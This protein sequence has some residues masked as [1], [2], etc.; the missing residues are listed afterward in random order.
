MIEGGV[1]DILGDQTL[2]VDIILRLGSLFNAFGPNGPMN[3]FLYD[4][5]CVAVC[6]WVLFRVGSVFTPA[7]HYDLVSDWPAEKLQETPRIKAVYGSQ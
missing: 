5:Q 3:C 6:Q 1:A 7:C 4:K 2:L